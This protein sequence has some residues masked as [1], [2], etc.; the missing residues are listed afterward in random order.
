MKL[1]FE[2]VLLKFNKAC[3]YTIYASLYFEKSELNIMY[4]IAEQRSEEWCV[5]DGHEGYISDNEE[6]KFQASPNNNDDEYNPYCESES[7]NNENDEVK[8]PSAKSK[9]QNL[10]KKALDSYFDTHSIFTEPEDVLALYNQ[11]K[12]HKHEYEQNKDK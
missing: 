9:N 8:E 6:N 10:T 12:S 1:K 7:E 4:G 2:R 3:D 5:L 11:M